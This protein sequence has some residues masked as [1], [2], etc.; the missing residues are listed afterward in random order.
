MKTSDKIALSYTSV[1]IGII[2]LI[3]IAFYI[4]ATF[5]LYNL[6]PE[7]RMNEIGEANYREIILYGNKIRQ[8]IAWMLCGLV[9]VSSLFVY[10]V[11]KHYSARMIERI[12]SS[13]QSEKAFVRS[14]SHELNN[15][16]TAIQGECEITLL[17][18]RTPA[19]YQIALNRILDETKRI[20]QLMKHLLFLSR[21]NED[22]L[23]NTTEPILIAE[24]LR[25]FAQGRV[26]FS[27][28]HFSFV[29]HA[30]PSLLKIAIE[31]I[32]SNALKYSDEKR[33]FIRLRGN[34]L[35]IEDHGIGIPADDL[36]YIFQPFFR[37]SNT[38]G[39]AGQGIGLSLSL[40]I[41]SAYGS[42][43]SIYSE[44]NKGTRVT[45]IFP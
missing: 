19:E 6:L 42:R 38:R 17:K 27:P 35:E 26:D 43:I 29:V 30:N 1:I 32:L 39:Y 12:N 40:R 36:E 20:I 9:V 33:V 44:I 21:E 7:E 11:G 31:N 22:I 14:A 3:A 34:E 5:Y 15:P 13:Y 41:L 18:E 16:L 23:Q 8:G 24:F 4:I 25:Q 2:V 45:I 28:D 10:G 37:A